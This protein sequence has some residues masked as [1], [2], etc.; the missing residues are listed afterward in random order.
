[1]LRSGSGGERRKSRGFFR[2]ILILQRNAAR[3]KFR[4]TTGCRCFPEYLTMGFPDCGAV[5]YCQV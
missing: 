3:V 4:G 1:M 2:L 5:D